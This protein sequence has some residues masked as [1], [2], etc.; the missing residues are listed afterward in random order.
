M[1]AAAVT[2]WQICNRNYEVVNIWRKQY[3]IYLTSYEG[4]EM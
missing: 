3:I 1:T 4:N 2:A